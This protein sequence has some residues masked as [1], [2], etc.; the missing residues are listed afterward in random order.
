MAVTR[1]PED[2]PNRE[3]VDPDIVKRHVRVISDAKDRLVQARHWF[4][5]YLSKHAPM[6]CESIPDGTPRCTREVDGIVLLSCGH[7]VAT[8]AE[9]GSRLIR[10]MS[11]PGVEALCS[12][13]TPELHPEHEPVT[14]EWAS[15]A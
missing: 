12:G 9:H 5:S 13:I 14:I 11:R 1:I 7:S 10:A 4:V 8:C 3:P 6:T 15:L 2:S